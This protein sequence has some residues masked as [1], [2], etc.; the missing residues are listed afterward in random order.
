MSPHIARV[1]PGW[2]AP[3][4][5]VFGAC[6]AVLLGL[7]ASQLYSS[8]WRPSPFSYTAEVYLP[9][10][11]EVCPG[12]VVTWQPRLIVNKTPTLLM[13]VRTLWDASEGRTLK[14][15]TE[16]KYFIWTQAQQGQTLNSAFGKYPLPAD[17]EPGFYE[18][19]SAAT[20]P[21]SDAAAY[22]VPFVIPESCFKRGGK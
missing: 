9:I 5:G 3:F 22:R 12:G 19:R 1:M 14:P 11:P 10:K 20:S 13:V 8:I 2:V 15:D 17:L 7:L 16:P 18:I 21:N 4:L 6:V